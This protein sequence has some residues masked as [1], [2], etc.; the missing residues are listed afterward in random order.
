MERGGAGCAVSRLAHDSP[1]PQ[2]PQQHATPWSGAD[3][4]PPAQS[5][6]GRYSYSRQRPGF[7]LQQPE[8]GVTTALQPWFLDA[9]ELHVGAHNRCE[10]GFEQRRYRTGS[11]QLERIL[12]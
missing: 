2:L 10:L 9:L 8:R 1:G 11:L 4:G 3:T 5:A 6:M 7:E 12:R